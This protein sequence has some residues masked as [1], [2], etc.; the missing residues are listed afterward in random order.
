MRTSRARSTLPLVLVML[1]ACSSTDADQP[2]LDETGSDAYS[3]ATSDASTDGDPESSPP[4]DSVIP[5]PDTTVDAVVDSGPIVAPQPLS[6]FIVVDQLGYR[7]GAE[8][9]AVVRSPQKGFD[10]STP[11]SP[12]AKF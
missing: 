6:P 3:D 5:L 4:S 2:P 8:K 9:I 10:S 7:T 11:F 1:G 12:G